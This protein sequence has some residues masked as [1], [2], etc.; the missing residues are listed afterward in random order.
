MIPSKRYPGMYRSRPIPRP[1]GL[2]NLSIKDKAKR[3]TDI[4]P[5]RIETYEC[6]E[7]HKPA[8]YTGLWYKYGFTCRACARKLAEVPEHIPNSQVPDYVRIKDDRRYGKT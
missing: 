6:R 5:I 7:C 1:R 3:D 4:F 8:E 2:K